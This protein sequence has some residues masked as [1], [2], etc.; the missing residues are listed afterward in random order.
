[1]ISGNLQISYF[2]DLKSLCFSNVS[3]HSICN[4]E[5]IYW[6]VTDRWL[7]NLYNTHSIFLILSLI[8]L[9]RNTFPAKGTWWKGWIGSF[10]YHFWIIS[11]CLDRHFIL[12][13]SS[14][15]SNWSDWPKR[16]RRSPKR[17]RP[18]SRRWEDK[19]DW[20]IQSSK[21]VLSCHIF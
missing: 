19:S 6:Y 20:K 21:M 13:H 1:M 5:L 2:N 12:I 8:S 16:Q 15:P 4:L 10:W 3:W 7:F 18:R 9:H 17:S 11:S 14:P